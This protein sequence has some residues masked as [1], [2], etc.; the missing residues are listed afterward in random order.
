MSST[1]LAELLLARSGRTVE[2]LSR[3]STQGRLFRRE[4]VRPGPEFSR[5]MALP[6]RVW[7]EDLDLEFLVQELTAHLKT[8]TGTRVLRAG[9]AIAL[10]ELYDYGTCLLASELGSGKTDVAFLAAV[11]LESKRP[12][13]L[14]PAKLLG[15]YNAHHECTR[16]GKTERE[17]RKLALEWKSGAEWKFLSYEKLSRDKQ[18]DFLERYEPDLIIGEEAHRLSNW[19]SGR[20]KRVARCMAA[21]PDTAFIPLTGSL[22]RKSLFECAHTSEWAL[23]ERSPIP[24]RIKHFH[25]LDEWRRALDLGT[26]DQDKMAAGVLTQFAPGG[27]LQAIRDAYTLYRQQTP[28]WVTVTGSGIDTSLSLVGVQIDNYPAH[29]DAKFQALRE[30]YETPDGEA[31]VEP[32]QLWRFLEMS[33]VGYWHRLRPEPPTVWKDAKRAWGQF[34]REILSF[35]E[36]HL[37]TEAQVALACSRGKIIDHGLHARWKEIRPMYNPDDHR[38][39]EWFDDTFLNWCVKW[40][41]KEQSPLFTPFIGFGEKLKEVT[42]LPYFHESGYDPDFGPIDEYKGGACIASKGAVMEGFNLQDRWNKGC[43][44]GGFAN[45]LE[46]HQLIGRFHRPG[47]DADE[48]EFWFP[49]GCIETLSALHRACE[50]A[51]GG[52]NKQ[53]KLLLGDFAV[54]SLEEAEKWSGPR[55][56]K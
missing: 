21:K 28:G 27:N 37:D 7:E 26:R 9:Q 55:W 30:S 50:E 17:F 33:S 12:L 22:K 3:N 15:K 8:P 42:G 32:K 53:H 24:R 6:R 19:R 10:K 54:D 34:V 25:E 13:F 44:I 16:L 56:V 38:T 41:E 43:L 1:K 18:T 4:G 14:A 45:S 23:R 36:P 52:D 31:F 29:V 11:V 40:L 47:Q 39:R 20:T 46:L 48:V 2:D 5:I 49:Y 51:E 35:N